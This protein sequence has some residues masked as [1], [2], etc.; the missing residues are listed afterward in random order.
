VHAQTL[1]SA[2]IA[3]DD[4]MHFADAALRFQKLLQATNTSIASFLN[5]WQH[6]GQRYR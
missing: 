3:F 6:D 4:A 1:R 5:I 2:V